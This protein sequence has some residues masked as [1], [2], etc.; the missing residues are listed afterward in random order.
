M[1]RMA[2]AGVIALKPE[3]I[4]LDEPTSQLDPQGTEE[5]FRAVQRLSR[6]GMTVVLVEHKVEKVALYCNRVM[7]LDGGKLIDFAPPESVFSRDDLM[8]FGVAPPVYTRVC[9]ELNAKRAG[10]PHFPVTL[11]EACEVLKGR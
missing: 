3:I 9:R 1:Q 4:V 10:S 5:V 11:E 2:I 7:L 6:E 8:Q